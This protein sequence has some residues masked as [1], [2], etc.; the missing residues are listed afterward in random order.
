MVFC[1]QDNAYP[2]VQ[3]DFL[4]QIMET[5]GVHSD[6]RKAAACMYTHDLEVKVKVNGHLGRPF[7]PRNGLVQGCPWAP[8]AYLMYFQT[9]ISLLA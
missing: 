9:F 7:S 4:Q 2:R 6:Y 1:D 5:M 8:I 3:W